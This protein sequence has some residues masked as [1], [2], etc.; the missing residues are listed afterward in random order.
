MNQLSQT[1]E[2]ALAAVLGQLAQPYLTFAE[3][4]LRSR[5]LQLHDLER[6]ISHP[7]VKRIAF[8]YGSIGNDEHAP[9]I[10]WLIIGTSHVQIRHNH[11]WYNI[12]EFLLY[13]A[14]KNSGGLNQ[15]QVLAEN[16]TRVGGVL[17]GPQYRQDD[18][19]RARLYAHPHVGGNPAA[20]CMNGD[21]A[22]LKEMLNEGDLW[23]AFEILDAALHS[24]GPGRAFCDVWNWPNAGVE[25]S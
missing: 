16:V 22:A 24:T 21:D 18:E 12:G 19:L 7:R 20:F 1:R 10:H 3:S 17:G 13:I 5:E 11:A 2:V 23:T 25:R 4:R 6:L 14:R 8:H 15:P 9:D